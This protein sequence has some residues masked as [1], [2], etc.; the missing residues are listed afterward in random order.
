[1]ERIAPGLAGVSSAA[2]LKAFD[3]LERAG[4]EMHSFMLMRHGK[5]CAEGWWKPFS[6][7]YKHIMFSFSKSITSTA[8]GFAEQEGLLSLDEKLTDIFPESVPENPS[9][10]LEKADIES[11]LTMSC[12]H[13]TEMDVFA[14]DGNMVAEFMS[15]PFM[16]EPGSHFLYNTMGTNML[17]AVLKR[18][19]GKNLTEFLRPRLFEP[20]GMSDDITCHVLPEGIEAGGF[21]LSMNTEDMARFIQFVAD[22][23]RINGKCLLNGAWFERASAKHIENGDGSAD[24]AMGYGYQFWRCKPDGVFRGDGAYGQYGIV[25]TKQDASL[26]ITSAEINMQACMDAIW[27]NLLPGLTDSPVTGE[28][29]AERELAYRLK[30]LSLRA[31]PGFQLAECQEAVSGRIYIP[32]GEYHSFTTIVGGAGCTAAK[33]PM[34]DND[35][36]ES[37]SFIFKDNKGFLEFTQRNGVYALELG[38]C[39]GY[40]VTGVN[41]VPFAV[42]ACWMSENK[43]EMLIRNLNT[44]SGRR[45]VFE[46]AGNKLNLTL[47]WTPPVGPGLAGTD[48]TKVVFNSE[49]V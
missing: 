20:L 16:Y 19:S 6:P 4:I 46:F 39:G 25:F 9:R 8:I 2:I 3:A 34:P 10:N 14:K 28:E 30:H 41:G 38:L 31:M 26:A 44:A 1:M 49:I 35:R 22:E 7:G 37:L 15:H 42:N 33:Y 13:G 23:G 47:D 24:S 21:G 43:L 36:M 27:D 17:C 11:L 12:G 5:V 18:K 45:A 48:F 32:E 29:E 40:A